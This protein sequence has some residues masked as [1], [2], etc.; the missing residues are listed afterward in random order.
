MPLHDT[1]RNIFNRLDP[2]A[3]SGIFENFLSEMKDELKRLGKG[4]KTEHVIS[5]DGKT[6][7]HSGNEK[8]KA[9]HVVTAFCSDLQLVLGQL[10]T[11]EK[12]NEITAIPKLLKML[13]IKGCTVTI[14]AMGT[15]R[16]IAAV[17][18][19]KEADYILGLKGNQSD[20]QE[21]VQLYIKSEL[22]DKTE[23][24]FAK[25]G[26]YAC[27][28]EKGHGRIETRKCW[29]FPDMTWYDRAEN[30]AGLTG[31]ALIRSTRTVADK[32]TTEDRLYIYSRETLTAQEFL[33][34]QRSHWSIENSLHWVLDVTFKEDSANIRFE[35]AA[36]VLNM[37]RKY[38]MQLLKTD[39]S[40]K[41]SMKSKLLR[42]SWDF[43]Y[44]LSVLQNA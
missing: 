39:T 44:A 24:D 19:E 34:M 26:R 16:E 35:N 7:R 29:V 30:W 2:E 20:L 21:A 10:T 5:V 41:G 36:I 33:D 37:F 22:E 15:Q 38:V 6:I 31:C 3:V 12:S 28:T 25:A 40:V 1:F 11:E 27:T 18:K 23:E 43:N 42:C 14:D 17:I 8:H 32:S 13:Q 4:E 9:Y